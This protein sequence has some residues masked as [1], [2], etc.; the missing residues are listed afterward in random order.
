MA[1]EI[2]QDYFQDKNTGYVAVPQLAAALDT[3]RSDA[4]VRQI[5]GLFGDTEFWTFNNR[6]EDGVVIS[7]HHF[8]KST[9]T[10]Q[11]IFPSTD[12][13][14]PFRAFPERT[15]FVTSLPVPRLMA[16]LLDGIDLSPV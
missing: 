2:Q 14:K 9:E 10:R 13:T 15:A 11:S 1:K 8:R 4:R 16:E 7:Q 3:V 12:N 5:Y 6:Y